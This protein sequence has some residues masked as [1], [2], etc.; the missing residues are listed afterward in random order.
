[1][2][3]ICLY[4]RGLLSVGSM[5]RRVSAGG[6]ANEVGG[7]HMGQSKARERERGQAKQTDEDLEPRHGTSKMKSRA[8][9][10]YQL[11]MGELVITDRK[12]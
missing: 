1:M 9:I 2:I 3:M 11:Q 12:M 5:A 8:S 7:W 6:D 4:M 10:Q